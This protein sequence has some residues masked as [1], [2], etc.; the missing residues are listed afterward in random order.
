PVLEF[1]VLRPRFGSDT[2]KLPFDPTTMH[3][4]D[5]NG[6]GRE[7]LCGRDNLGILC[8]PAVAV[9]GKG[10]R[11]MFGAMQRGGQRG[12]SKTNA[13]FDR[14]ADFA[15]VDGD[16][17]LDVCERTAEGIVCGLSDGYRFGKLKKWSV[18]NDFVDAAGEL[19]RFGDLNGDGRADLCGETH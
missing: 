3:F 10:P 5:V 1:S 7:D 11:T 2:E 19:V 12:A 17:H 8:A 14:P 15:D 16:G 18:G 6:D 13:H 9:A 4:A